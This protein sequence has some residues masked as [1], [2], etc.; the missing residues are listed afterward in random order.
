MKATLVFITTKPAKKGDIKDCI[1]SDYHKK[2]YFSFMKRAIIIFLLL[3]LVPNLRAQH[4]NDNSYNIIDTPHINS[5]NR[6]VRDLSAKGFNKKADSVARIAL[7]MAQTIGY[8]KGEATAL[9]NMGYIYHDIGEYPQALTKFFE[10]MKINEKIGNK[11]GMAAGYCN[12]GIILDAQGKFNEAL[13]YQKMSLALNKEVLNDSKGISVSYC[14]IGLVYEELGNY[15]EAISNIMQSITIAQQTNDTESVGR[16]YINLGIIYADIGNNAEAIRYQKKGLALDKMIGYKLNMCA[17]YINLGDLYTAEKKYTEAKKYLD[18]ALVLNKAILDK[19]TYTSAYTSYALLDSATGN[20]KLAYEHYKLYLS[21]QDSLIS[22][23]SLEK[24][25][26]LE[27][28][29]KYDKRDDSI[30]AVQE[31]TEIIRTA[32]NKRKSILTYSIIIILILSIISAILFINRQQLKYKKDKIIFE[33]N[34]ALLKLESE[35]KEEELLHAKKSL[36]D[37]TRT[38]AEKNE[39]MEQFKEDIEKLKSLKSKELNEIRVDQLEYLNKATIL[40]DEDWDKFKNLFEQV[41]KGF[42]IRL[43]E[44][45]PDLTQAETR[46]ICLTKLKLNTKQMAGILGVSLDTISKTRYRLKKKMGLT[47]ETSLDD[48][49]ES[50]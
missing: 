22:Q 38:M 32:E 17:A 49:A 45:L 29:Y 9:G 28:T 13:K 20:F 46:L 42:F 16:G 10:S 11:Q 7:S 30:K 25:T 6:L 8:E 31:K 23:A 15:P 18:S 5:L 26:N 3:L 2:I 4:I 24:I 19:Y 47:E 12:I 27:L 36:E 33:N 35:R 34:V 37:Y 40:T 39:L 1:M 43:K 21:Y 44:K 41:Y 50:I 14:N 48:I